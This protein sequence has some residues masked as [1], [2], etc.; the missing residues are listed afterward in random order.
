[1]TSTEIYLFS[2]NEE[3]RSNWKKVARH[4]KHLDRPGHPSA[5]NDQDIKIIKWQE[6]DNSERLLRVI[7]DWT[8]KSLKHTLGVFC[9]VL[10]EIHLGKL[11][12]K[13]SD[14]Q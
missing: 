10:V 5:F 12:H 9:D 14:H 3:A 7:N 4:L 8:D 6:D 13:L 1:M 11:C 2:E